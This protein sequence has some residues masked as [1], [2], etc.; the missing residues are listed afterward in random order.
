MSCEQ[1]IS[2]LPDVA[3]YEVEF[4]SKKYQVEVDLVENTETY[5]HVILSVDDGSFP[6]SFFPLTS[7]FIR[8][9]DGSGT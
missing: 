1:L 9:K 3:A 2:E 6:D 4:E 7:G 5:V 8:S